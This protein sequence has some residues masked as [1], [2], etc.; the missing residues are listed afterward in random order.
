MPGLKTE[1]GIA[2][3]GF[4][5]MAWIVDPGKNAGVAGARRRDRPSGVPQD[6]LVKQVAEELGY[7]HP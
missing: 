7:R 5:W 3:I 1:D 6:P 4:A 2:D